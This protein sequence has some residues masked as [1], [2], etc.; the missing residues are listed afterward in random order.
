LINPL[1]EYGI[2]GSGFGNDETKRYGNV[3]GKERA[4]SHYPRDIFSSV[5][6]NSS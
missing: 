5:G 6:V 4:N 1:P 2:E 3:A